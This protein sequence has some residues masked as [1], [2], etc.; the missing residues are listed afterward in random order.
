MKKIITVLTL[1]TLFAFRL[2]AQHG[3][4][5]IQ[6]TMFIQNLTNEEFTVCVHETNHDTSR[7][8]VSLE[9][10]EVR[11]F[12]AGSAARIN[13][14]LHFARSDDMDNKK[15]HYYEVTGIFPVM[16][17]EADTAKVFGIKKIGEDTYVVTPGDKPAVMKETTKEDGF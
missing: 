16:F 11:S 15:Y 10:G 13:G 3:E 9:P 1:A 6:N 17:Y 12:L 14:P 5:P 7:H 2:D 4:Q 8:I